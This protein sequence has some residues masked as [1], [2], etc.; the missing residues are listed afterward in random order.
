MW[1]AGGSRIE[2]SADG[3]EWQQIGT[4][5]GTKPIYRVDLT[6]TDHSGIWVRIVKDTNCLH[7]RRFLVYGQKRS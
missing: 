1:R 7:L 6:E 3:K 4:L 2:I 5:Q